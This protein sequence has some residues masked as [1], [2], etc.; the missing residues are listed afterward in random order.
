MEIKITAK[1]RASRSRRFEDTN[2]I[3]S[4][5]MRPKTLGTF[6]KGSPVSTNGE[7]PKYGSFLSQAQVILL[8]ET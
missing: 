3:M 1:F 5:E 7:R 8:G 4:S 6:E 2:R